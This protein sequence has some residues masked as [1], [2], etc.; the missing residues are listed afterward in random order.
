MRKKCIKYF[1]ILS[2]FT[3]FSQFFSLTNN[4]KI[5]KKNQKKN[6]NSRKRNKKKITIKKG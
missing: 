6:P 3:V 1:L 4:E 5:R 2:I